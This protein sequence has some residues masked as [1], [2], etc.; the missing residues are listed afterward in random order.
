MIGAITGDIV[1]SIY[2]GAAFKS[3]D[4]LLFGKGC[5]FTDDTVCT[6]AVADCLMH[7]GD[8]A[9]YLRAYVRRHPHR[10]YG[11]MFRQWAFSDTGP[12]NSWGNGS[13]MRVS[14]VAHVARDEAELME[15]AESSSA[16]THNHPSA[17]AG[18]QAVALTMWMARAGTEPN[19]IRHEIGRRFGYDLTRTV[20]EIRPDYEFD[21]SS[22]GTVPQAITC[23]LEATSFEG[24]IRN[25]IS[26]GGDAD[27]LA[28]IAGGIAEAMF[29]VPSGISN[30][31]RG[32]LTED[33][34][35]V[36][37]RFSELAS[38]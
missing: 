27:T 6:V 8:F 37:D 29:G 5:R 36:V 4:F 25:A 3:R 10:G 28:C 12:Y 16:V 22:V 33:F 23:A 35:D 2:E 18:A 9:S 15:L 30:A 17:I 21:V 7:D 31:A 14:P 32:Y 20:D 13:A 24:A 1:G 26:I 34:I 19:S 11:G 38:G